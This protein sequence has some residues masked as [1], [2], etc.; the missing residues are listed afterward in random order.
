MLT[1]L[2]SY[3][4]L[5]FGSLFAILSP[6]GT[7]PIFVALTEGDDQAQRIAMARRA[8]LIAFVVMAL[9]SVAGSTILAA[10]LVS[11]PALQIAGGVVILRVGLEMLGGSRRRLTPEE[12]AEAIDKDDVAVTPLAVPML[13]G[14][15]S[16]TVAIVLGSQAQG[17]AQYVVLVGITA[18]I[19]AGTFALLWFAVRFSAVVGQI[20][21]RVV[22]RLMGLLLAAVAVQFLIN[23]VRDALPLVIGAR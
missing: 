20:T 6:L 9:F 2:A 19:Y 16:I 12:R 10:F 15:G 3:A 22:G 8:T 11:I 7:V 4:L 21:L 17:V 23:G 14:P 13:C 1:D 18:L 5:A